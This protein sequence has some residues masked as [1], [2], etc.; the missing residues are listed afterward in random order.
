M[1]SYLHRLSAAFYYS[2]SIVSIV[3]LSTS[4][5]AAD[6]D[7]WREG[8]PD[9]GTMV[10]VRLGTGDAV[11][12]IY[13][14]CQGTAILVD[15]ALLGLLVVPREGVT[16]TMTSEEYTE[17]LALEQAERVKAAVAAELAAG[18][19][20]INE[21]VADVETTA[22]AAAAEPALVDAYDEW[23]SYVE[24]GLNGST[25]NSERYN[26]RFGIGTIRARD[27]EELE[28]NILYVKAKDGGDVSEEK[29]LANARNDWFFPDS[30]LRFFVLGTAE[31][32]RFK[33]YD[34]RFGLALGPAYE[35]IINDM[36]S[37]VGRAGVGLSYE[38]GGADEEVVPEVLLAY[39]F[40]HIIQEGWAVTSGL[41]LYPD[42]SELGEFRSVLDAALQ[43]Q[44]PLPNLDLRIGIQNRYESSPTQPD[45]PPPPALPLPRVKENDLDYF[46]TA[47][48]QF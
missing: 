15:H 48:W 24:G 41:V 23:D 40:A 25:G 26:S 28:L 18:D 39:D 4:A 29:L 34:Y 16:A 17:E 8:D 3:M 14:G 47:L 1:K 35:F 13:S 46:V 5:L 32:D 30:P 33:E 37:L 43:I 27:T 6:A 9:S 20:V 38:L 44:T 22:N 11:E 45:Q 7:C 31:D 42:L 21:A 10:V 36:T 2:A 19:E 12:G